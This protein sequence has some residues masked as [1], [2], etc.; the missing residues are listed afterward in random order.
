MPRAPAFSS[1]RAACSP[2]AQGMQNWIM[3]WQSW[4]TGGGTTCIDAEGFPYC[5]SSC[6]P[7]LYA[8]VCACASVSYR[9]DVLQYVCLPGVAELSDLAASAPYL[10]SPP[11]LVIYLHAPLPSLSSTVGMGLVC[12]LCW[13]Q[14]TSPWSLNPPH[15]LTELVTMHPSC[16][17]PPNRPHPPAKCPSPRR[18]C[19]R[20]S[21]PK[22]RECFASALAGAD[23]PL[24]QLGHLA[25]ST[26]GPSVEELRRASKTSRSMLCYHKIELQARRTSRGT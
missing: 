20:C 15:I 10:F 7:C 3:Q 13:P 25:R 22:I 23:L 14:S 11:S 26:G 5:L 21:L 9:H 8:C 16:P 18:R 1:T 12:R 4:P 17:C 6:F 24:C 19:S 2:A